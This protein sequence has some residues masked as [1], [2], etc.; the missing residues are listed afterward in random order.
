M[1]KALEKREILLYADDTLISTDDKDDNLCH[2]NLSKDMENI[3]K[4][5]MMYKLKLTEIKTKLLEINMDS[6][7]IFKRNNAIIEKVNSLRYLR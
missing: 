4:W 6:N 1:E 2:K 5:L 7:I 3:N